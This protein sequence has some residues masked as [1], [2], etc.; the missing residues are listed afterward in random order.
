MSAAVISFRMPLLRFFSQDEMVLTY[1]SR[2]VVAVLL[3]QWCYAVFNCISNMV[4]GVGF[5]KYTTVINLLMLWAVRIPTAYLINR[6]YD[7]TYIM[8]SIAISFAFGMLCMIG[9]YFFSPAWKGIISRA[10]GRKDSGIP[11]V[12]YRTLSGRP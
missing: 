10:D 7:G 2:Y 12:T 4:N 3:S 8:L 6:F 9:Y 1:A 5:V 11:L